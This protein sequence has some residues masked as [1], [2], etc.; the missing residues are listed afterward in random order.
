L[1]WA[2]AA[3][4]GVAMIAQAKINPTDPQPMCNMC[5]GTYIPLSE[6]EAYTKKAIQ[7]KLTDQQVRD[8]ELGRAPRGYRDGSTVPGWTS[9]RQTR[10]R[11]TISSARSIM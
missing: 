4:C 3:C 5:P 8:I 9:P 6:L 2:V 10:W 7:Q 1:G 11:N